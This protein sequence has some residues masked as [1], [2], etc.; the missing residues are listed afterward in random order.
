LVDRN[1]HVIG[2]G[3][4]GNPRGEPHCLDVPCP[5]ADLPSGTGLNK[6]GAIHAE[7]NALLQCRN[8]MEIEYAYVTASPC[9][10]CTKLLKNTGCIVIVYGEEY[11][12]GM[13]GWTTDR[14]A[15]RVAYKYE[16]ANE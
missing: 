12:Q 10:E 3:Y 8:V 5:G 13:E 14:A 4:N 7:A 15:L 9:T 11:P 6:C 2:T 16:E 1:G